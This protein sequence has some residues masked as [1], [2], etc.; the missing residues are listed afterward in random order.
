MELYNEPKIAEYLALGPKDLAKDISPFLRYVSVANEECLCGSHQAM[1]SELLTLISS[2][3][4]I[5]VHGSIE[6]ESS[7]MTLTDCEKAMA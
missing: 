7:R 2:S 3:I 4:L 6:N 5:V 1:P